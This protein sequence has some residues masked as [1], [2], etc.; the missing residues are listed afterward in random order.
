MSGQPLA[1]PGVLH[2]AEPLSPSVTAFLAPA[3]RE[4]VEHGVQQ[5][6]VFSRDGDTSPDPIARFD[7]KVRLVEV[8]RS[9]RWQWSF[10]RALQ[11]ELA[12]RRYDAI[13]LHAGMAGIVGRL[14][15]GSLPEHPPVFYSPHGLSRPILG[16]ATRLL[17]R[18]AVFN[19][20]HPVGGDHGEAR[21]LE[22]LTRRSATVL[23]NPLEAAFFEVQRQP[24]QPAIVVSVAYSAD[25]DAAREF[26]ELAARF[27]FAGEPVRF[28]WLGGEDPAQ[29][30]MLR[31]AGV[32]VVTGA[33]P[34]TVRE[35][36]ADALVYVQTS[37]SES[38]PLSILQA[39]A[40]GLPSVL[41]DGETNRGLLAHGE[42]GFLA[43]DMSDM[44]Q[45]VK[46]L[47]DAPDSAR[48]IGLAAQL[49]ARRRFHP[50]RFRQAL[51]TLYRLDGW[52]AWADERAL[53][54]AAP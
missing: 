37:R 2:A 7:P 5:T 28:R 8:D 40:V 11:A 4:L 18:M 46:R 50:R 31:A 21:E 22:R 6:L 38:P 29:A 25:N 24:G 33:D 42:S 23:E 30:A 32:E 27:H 20:C 51:L 17:D 9:G 52:R 47:L 14:A 1:W 41:P 15:L 3:T 36:L 13:H 16:A 35:H 44:A 54:A 48:Q 39:M 26:A 34:Q 12:R 43:Q 53:D 45:Q 10:A 49:E 19:G